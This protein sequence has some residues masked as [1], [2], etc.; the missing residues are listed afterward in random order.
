MGMSWY[1]CTLNSGS[2]S[3][4]VSENVIIQAECMYLT[5]LLEWNQFNPNTFNGTHYNETKEI[6]LT[7]L[8]MK[9]LFLSTL[10]PWNISTIR[11]IINYWLVPGGGGSQNVMEPVG[12]SMLKHIVSNNYHRIYFQTYPVMY[13]FQYRGAGLSKP[14][15]H[16]HTATNWIDCAKELI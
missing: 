14:S 13:L 12:I 3:E 2:F 5:S 11:H 8:H 7:D 1:P 15:L 6:Q 4:I 16:C 10:S 9:R